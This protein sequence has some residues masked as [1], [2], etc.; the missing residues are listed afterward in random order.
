M[1][2][3]STVRT[4]AKLRAWRSGIRLPVEARAFLSS[5]TFTPAQRSTHAPIQWVPGFLLEGKEVTYLHPVPRL[6]MSGAIPLFPYTPSRRGQE[7]LNLNPL[8]LVRY[9]Y[10]HAFKVIL[11]NTPYLLAVQ[12]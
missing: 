11:S 3:S 4:P 1:R 9:S 7:K 2:L 8:I 5:K 12:D 10:I 6:R